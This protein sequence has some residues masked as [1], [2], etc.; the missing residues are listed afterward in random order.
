MLSISLDYVLQYEYSPSHHSKETL[1]SI[2]FSIFYSNMHYDLGSVKF[3]KLISFVCRWLLKTS[4]LRILVYGR[5]LILDDEAL[6]SFVFSSLRSSLLSYSFQS[7][8]GDR[9][10]VLSLNR[11]DRVLLFVSSS[12]PL[13]GTGFT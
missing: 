7:S 8:G 10:S 3:H 5:V 6:V 9:N 4:L 13:H 2:Y 12:T 11:S 1:L